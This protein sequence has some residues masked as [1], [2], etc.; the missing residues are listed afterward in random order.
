M[1]LDPGGGAYTYYP[2][3]NA[4]SIRR[5]P[6][7]QTALVPYMHTPVPSGA[8]VVMGNMLSSISPFIAMQRFGA[9]IRESQATA[10][11]WPNMT[12]RQKEQFNYQRLHPQ[13]VGWLDSLGLPTSSKNV[14]PSLAAF[15]PLK[16]RGEA[17]AIRTGSTTLY[18]AP[19]AHAITIED[20]R[21]A[22]TYLNWEGAPK[23]LVEGKAVVAQDPMHEIIGS[24]KWSPQGLPLGPGSEL[25]VGERDPFLPK[26]FYAGDMYIK[27]E[28]QGNIRLFMELARPMIQDALK[29]NRP[30]TAAF[31][32]PKMKRLA[33]HVLVKRAG[34][35]SAQTNQGPF[36]NITYFP[37]W[38]LRAERA[39]IDPWQAWAAQHFLPGLMR[40]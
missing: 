14:L 7:G 25:P 27:P 12:P 38:W 8:G 23:K 32:E 10:N 1:P 34:Y 18:E 21:N 20:Y 33:E 5:T 37:N 31:A 35:G 26:S 13:P 22:P 15:F 19:P 16:G 3:S 28:E 6:G 39:G 36:T 29:S 30:I 24:S 9:A 40:R 4:R 17:G 11:A 2:T